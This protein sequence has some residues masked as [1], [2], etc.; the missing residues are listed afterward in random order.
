MMQEIVVPAKAG[1]HGAALEVVWGR[2]AAVGW[3][4]RKRAHQLTL[5]LAFGISGRWWA[6]R[7]GRLCPPY[8]LNLFR[9]F[10]APTN[11]QDKARGRRRGLTYIDPNR[12]DDNRSSLPRNGCRPQTCRRTGHLYARDCETLRRPD[13][14]D[15]APAA[16]RRHRQRLPKFRA[17]VSPCVG[18]VSVRAP[19]PL[20]SPKASC[21]RSNSHKT[22]RRTAA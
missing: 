11:L 16:R 8:G 7:K 18:I 1:T 22:F 15:I 2:A 5:S 19:G 12:S 17:Q 6:R 3:A 13:R 10:A 14:R 21:R 20:T 4:K 9:A